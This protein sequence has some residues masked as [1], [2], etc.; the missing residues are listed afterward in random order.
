MK[1]Y[2]RSLEEL[3]SNKKEKPDKQ[4]EF[5]V[6][7]LSDDEIKGKSS[8]RDFLKMLGFTVG[9]ATLATSC[10]MPVRKAIPFLNKPENLTP[11]EAN[12]YATSF[13]DGNDYCSILVKTREGRPIKIEGN[14]LSGVTKGGTSARVQASVLNL[15]DTTR[16]QH[17]LMNGEKA[18]WEEVDREITAKLQ[19]ISGRDKEIVILSS[20]IISPSTNQL[21]AEFLEKYPRSS[22]VKYDAVSASGIINANEMSFNKAV[23]PDYH[24]DKADLIVSFNA[25]FLG[26]WL[27]SIEYIKGYS[28]KRNLIDSKQMSK[29]IQLES[30]MS[31]TGSNAD[32]RISIKPSDEA[33]I[34]LNLYN[35]IALA[36]GLE[37]FNVQSS[38]VDVKPMAKEL[39]KN[40]GKSL[41]VCG[42]NDTGTQ[43]IVNSINHALKNYGSTID[44]NTSLN[45]KQA[46]DQQFEALLSKIKQGKIGALIVY[47]CNPLYDYHHSNDLAEALKKVELTI[48]FS[49][50]PDETATKM[51]FVCPDSNYLESWNDAE[52]KTGHYSLIQPTIPKLFNTRQA[53]ESLLKWMGKDPDYYEYIRSYWEDNLLEKDTEH[54]GFAGFWNKHLH[55]GVFELPQTRKPQP[56]F[57]QTVLKAGKR[58]T[59]KTF[60]IV[61]YKSIAMGNG[62]HA[63][64]PWLQELPD[65]ISKVTWDN[66]IAVSPTDAE[67]NDWD[68]EDLLKLD[69]GMEL[70]VYVQPGQAKGVVSIALGYG[71]THAGKVGDNVGKNAYPLV[72]MQ[73]GNKHLMASATNLSST[74]NTYPLALTQTHNTMEGRDIVRETTLNDWKIRPDSGNEIHEYHEKRH[75]T[76]YPTPEFPNLH[77]GLAVNLNSCIGCGACAIACQAENNVAVIGKEE[78]K[79]R[80]IM[81]W[82]RIDRY[83]SEDPENPETYHQ[84]VMCQQC[85]NAPCENVCPVA[86]TPH[87]NEGLNMMAYNRCIGTRYCMNNCP[88]RVRRFNWFEYV[89]NNNFPYNM[90]NQLGKMVLNPDVVVRSRGVVEKCSFC[91]QRLQEKKLE[92]KKEGR[93]LRDG[94][95]QTACQ[96]ACPSDAI[97]F[98]NLNDK[99]SK[100]YKA[101]ENPRNYHL[102]EEL[103]TLPSVGYLTKVRNKETKA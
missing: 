58:K 21:I 75:V 49:D 91:S 42:T 102:L 9:Y 37:T 16:L 6:D 17:P 65:A 96:Q 18:G 80:R 31:L 52:P 62:R 45:I 89:N 23:I 32:E 28:S 71:R 73:N 5:S 79:K 93:K 22:H 8:R 55:D 13:F 39:L 60:E 66:Y 72:Q 88:Y 27:S 54:I 43:L 86:A 101:F 67:E 3:K 25:D 2:W 14:T 46:R 47:N 10:E 20:S 61:L 64:N 94:D 44:L 87:S 33:V 56:D 15:Y 99:E 68:T 34:L 40:Q 77:W 81:H 84:P 82:I 38:P 1:K 100:I 19:N 7:G 97:V 30:Y 12:F 85:D 51:Q 103:H 26:N 50:I 36:L 48:S 53:Q 11:G 74:G 24:F 95:V 63:N 76:L 57:K 41:V 98:G 83:F 92:A 29:H 4:P 78:V 59:N 69:N 35:E 70:P 90:D